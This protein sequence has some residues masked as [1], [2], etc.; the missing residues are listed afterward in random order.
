MI[1]KVPTPTQGYQEYLPGMEPTAGPSPDPPPIAP[2]ALGLLSR[3]QV[4]HR[5]QALR[6]R[7]RPRAAKR[8]L[9]RWRATHDLYW[10]GATF[11]G[12]AEYVDPENGRPRVD[13]RFH[14][15]LCRYLSQ[16]KSILLLLPRDHGKS[17]WVTVQV[18][19][20]LLTHPNSIRTLIISASV[21]LARAR[22]RYLADLLTRPACLYYFTD[23]VPEPGRGF[24]QWDTKNAYDLTVTKSK[25]RLEAQHQVMVCGFGA[26][27]TG[28]HY[29]NIVCD[30]I[31]D[32]KTARSETQRQLAAER[33]I[34]LNAL[35]E[36]TGRFTVL[37][38]R[39][40]EDDIY[41][42]LLKS[43][44]LSI[45]LVR[46]ATE[47]PEHRADEELPA[48]ILPGSLDDPASEP[49]YSFYDKE[50]LREAK[51]AAY[52]LTGRD[53]WFWTQYYNLP[54]APTE[55]AF[56]NLNSGTYPDLPANIR[57]T[58]KVYIALDTANTAHAHSDPNG[59]AVGYL[60][61]Q[62]VLFIEE[63]REVQGTWEEACT[64]LIGL[65]L[66]HQPIT[67]VAVETLLGDNWMTL[68]Q[69]ILSD[70]MRSYRARGAP[71][72]RLPTPEIVTP[73]RGQ[74]KEERIDVLFG[75]AFRTG[76]AVIR[77]DQRD[78]LDQ[79]T[80]FPKGRHDDLIDAAATLVAISSPSKRITTYYDTPQ[81][82][83]RFLDAR[84]R[85]MYEPTNRG[86]RYGENLVGYR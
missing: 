4:I 26:L 56:P 10:F 78:L 77:A 11:L 24:T 14:L 52:D 15:D 40:H 83:D 84:L 8:A 7:H 63:T 39:Y 74:T 2:L 9:V 86:Y 25:T 66:H 34:A 51:D 30:D 38:T 60:S 27:I 13:P 12:L 48:G 23:I 6:R 82:R 71:V 21:S 16:R 57:R 58:C 72:P 43:S 46:S 80:S 19:Q 18:A 28:H 37:G 70:R 5:Y 1:P 22:L 79:M 61:P 44:M 85:Y 53:E 20:D 36:P 59:L 75:A 68:Y 49:I 41:S 62:N 45:H 81:P 64:A 65:A 76:A 47:R 69:R 50:M 67:A 35:K 73:R 3:E 29:D 33:L 55:S 17:T 54:R 32:E 42:R 31:V